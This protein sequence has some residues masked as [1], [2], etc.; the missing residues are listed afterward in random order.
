M[1][2]SHKNKP[3]TFKS[4]HII[5]PILTSLEE[6]GYSTPTPIQEQAIPVILHKK[7][8][9]ASAQTG[10]GKTAAFAIPI[11]QLLEKS[12]KKDDK[13]MKIRCLVLTPTRELAVQVGDS[14]KAYGRH[15]DIYGTVIYGGVNQGKQTSALRRGVDILVATPGRLLDLMDQGFVDLRSLEIFVLDEADRMLDM[16]FITDINKILQEV[17]AKRQT[18]FFSATLPAPI[19]KLADSMLH[20]P[21]F[22]EVKPAES[23]AERIE[24]SLYY[25]EKMKKQELL[26]HVLQDEGI[27]SALVFTRTKYGADIVVRVLERNGITAEAIHGNKAQNTRQ[28]ALNNFKAGKTRV[29]V[30]TDIAARGIDVDNLEYVINYEIPNI[31]ETYVHRIGRTGR[32]GMS[33]IA[34]SFCD[35]SEKPF[36]RDIEKLMGKKIPVI[37]EHPFASKGAQVVKAGTKETESTK[38]K[39]A[40]KPKQ[41][42]RHEKKEKTNLHKQELLQWFEKENK[43]RKSKPDREHR[44]EKK[45]SHTPKREHEELLE[46]SATRVLSPGEREWKSSKRAERRGQRNPF[47]RKKKKHPSKFEGKKRSEARGPSEFPASSHRGNRFEKRTADEP[48]RE[49]EPLREFT[50]GSK[51]FA[52]KG[53][54]NRPNPYSGV[55]KGK[56]IK[57]RKGR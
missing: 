33:G 19:V 37:L 13:H 36:I 42:P 34:L 22:V 31:A 18:L 1:T 41:E 27:K 43:D 5:D 30:A 29:L 51:P 12:T 9:L 32:A 38:K 46:K 10:T 28:R 20:E 48:R 40:H 24:Q 15:L 52:R 2:D 6:E 44:D 23:T 55:P 3:V 7:D 56:G 25:V 53:K 45:N 26:I 54:K 21:K 49:R 50:K 39:S 35:Q 14:F 11:L 8:L 16:G 57:R 4:L 17:P 47:D